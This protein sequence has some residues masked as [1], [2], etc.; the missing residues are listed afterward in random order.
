MPE[1]GKNYNTSHKVKSLPTVPK[2]WIYDFSQTIQSQFPSQKN[3][4]KILA[5]FQKIHRTLVTVTVIV[6]V[7]VSFE[8][9][10]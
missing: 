10:K 9:P 5:Y 6:T 8:V 4:F 2:F 1:N 3:I 7:T